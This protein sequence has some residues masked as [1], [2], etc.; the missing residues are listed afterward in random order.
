M[1]GGRQTMGR[2]L[3]HRTARHVCLQIDLRFAGNGDTYPQHL[4][5][6]EVPVDGQRE[7]GEYARQR[8][9]AVAVG[10]TPESGNIIH[11]FEIKCSRQDL[12]HE[13]NSP[14]KAEAALNNCDRFWLVVNDRSIMRDDDPIPFEWGIMVATDSGLKV[15]REAADLVAIRTRAAQ[16]RAKKPVPMGVDHRFVASLVASGMSRPTYRRAMGFQSGWHSGFREGR[17]A[18][19]EEAKQSFAANF[20]DMLTHGE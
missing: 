14:W 18:G 3:P 20:L 12:M 16:P 13:L 2:P 17:K 15:L 4:V 19:F 8:I 7:D 9:D 1:G 10:L 11:G 5:L 6:F